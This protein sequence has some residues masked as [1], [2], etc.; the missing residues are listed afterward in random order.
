MKVY[1]NGTLFDS[2]TVPIV[3]DLSSMD[4]GNIKAMSSKYSLYGSF[5]ENPPKPYNKLSEFEVN[6]H[7]NK[8]KAIINEYNDTKKSEN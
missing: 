6:Q 5:P 8:V 2:E 4:K 1:V 3:I 7:M